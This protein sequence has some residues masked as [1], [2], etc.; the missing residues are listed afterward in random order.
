MLCPQT[1]NGL[2]PKILGDNDLEAMRC[3]ALYY[4]PDQ[5]SFCQAMS[6]GTSKTFISQYKLDRNA[7]KTSTTRFAIALFPDSI[8]SNPEK[9]EWN[10]L[11]GDLT[12]HLG[13]GIDNTTN[14]CLTCMD[15]SGTFICYERTLKKLDEDK[16]LSGASLK[17]KQILFI[18]HMMK[19]TYEL[20]MDERYCV[21]DIAFQPFIGKAIGLRKD[22]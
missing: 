9:G 2:F 15:G 20:M 1:T 22:K 10:G 11:F 17:D 21:R 5:A 3:L 8:P 6:V 12:L 13:I 7:S 19:L 18:V 16:N 4:I 14:D